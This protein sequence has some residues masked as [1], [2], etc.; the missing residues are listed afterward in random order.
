M[1]GGQ[2][3]LPIEMATGTGETRTATAFIKRLF[4]AGAVTR[5]LFLVDRIA[6]AAQAEDVFTD[7]LRDYPC[8]VLRPGRGFGRARQRRFA[9][10]ESSGK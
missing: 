4:E 7:H 10:R 9:R 2:R 6:Y 5:V 1:A 8:H 3:K